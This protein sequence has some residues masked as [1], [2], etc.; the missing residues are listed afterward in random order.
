MTQPPAHE[1]TPGS[2]AW[3]Q[4]TIDRL[5]KQAA[6][7]S[8]RHRRPRLT[9]KKNGRRSANSPAVGDRAHHANERTDCGSLQD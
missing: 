9:R 1:P 2:D 5:R 8:R 4:Q 3:R 7:V 6:S